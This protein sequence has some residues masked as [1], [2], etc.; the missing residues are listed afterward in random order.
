MSQAADPNARE[1]L[2]TEY[3]S[4]LRTY[5][6]GAGETALMRAYEL[7]RKAAGD[8]VGLLELATIH[9][10]ALLEL[11][12]AI[13]GDPSA[14]ALA[15]QFFAEVLSTFEINLR[16]YQANARLLGLSE[17]LARENA[18]IDRARGQL[19]TIL[20]ATTA[21]IYLKD[22]AGRY[23]FVNRQFQKVFCPHGEQVIGKTDGEVWAGTVAQ[24]LHGKD[25]DVLASRISQEVEETNYEEDGPHTYVTLKFPLLESTGA[26]YALC[27]VATDIT[28]RKRAEEAERLA[29]EAAQL[30]SLNRSL[31]AEIA[32][33]QEAEG[34]AQAQFERLKL[35]HD[36]T[37]AIASRQEL[38]SIFQVVTRSLEEE[39]PV[40]F[41]CICV[42]DAERALTVASIGIGS[43]KVA[44]DLEIAKDCR[45][46]IEDNSLEPC[47]EGILVYEPDNSRAAMRFPQRLA[48]GGLRSLVL[49]PLLFEEQL[50][51]L[52][53]VARRNPDDF[54]GGECEFLQQLCEHVALAAHQWQLHAELQQAYDNLRA[55]QEAIT[56][57]ERLRALGQMA[58]GIAH[59]INNAI[60]PVGLYT[61]SLLE[62]EPNLSVRARDCLRIIQRSIDDVSQ[63]VSRMREFYRQRESQVTPAA[64]RVNELVQH[65]IDLTRARWN[66]M[67]QQRGVV[68]KLET[69]LA[70][71]SPTIIGVESEIRGALVNLIF[72]AVDALPEGGTVTVRTRV[73]GEVPAADSAKHVHVEVSDTGVGMDADTRR[74]CMEPFFTTKGERGTGLGLAMVFGVAQ[75][76]TAGI[77]ID[78]A[79]G[80]GTTVHLSFPVNSV[81]TS[82]APPATVTK[83]PTNMRILVV[84]DDPMLLKSLKEV[85]EADGHAV[86]TADGGQAGIEAVLAPKNDQGFSVVITDL[87][88]PHVNGLQ[89]AAAVKRAAPATPVI[90][91]T[92]WGQ[93]LTAEGDLPD[94][95]NLVLG[96]P[97]KLRDLREALAYCC[98]PEKR[99]QSV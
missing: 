99:V 84:D 63:T 23:L 34:K 50:F 31:H 59:D 56:Q 21:I 45:I 24:T 48:R 4:T 25:L 78:S 19:A 87:G 11:P 1:L 65:V 62:N 29:K 30:E 36:I 3:A 39:M 85:L 49:G 41:C 53:V 61:E 72:N 15:A 57:Q 32:V 43:E 37:R 2:A 64:V 66:D 69:E 10:D 54:A 44:R 18:E 67:P 22:S 35:L 93:R 27:C 95:V 40:D 79:L 82:S 9:H 17:A 6:V 75:R 70:P 7:G 33:R 8:G 86:S 76:H 92:G 52:L 91:L 13:P 60:S 20:N 55:T 5:V 81:A 14:V 51:G 98:R 90:L 46:D 89:V 83:L 38:S 97:P 12:A 94:H 74:R 71:G 28:E 42:H 47:L 68:I 80:K 58:S 96:K 26:P 16:A 88:M 73:D 77:T